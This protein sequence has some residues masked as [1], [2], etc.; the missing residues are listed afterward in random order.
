MAR[1]IA[2]SRARRWIVP[3]FAALIIG[4][5]FASAGAAIE[6]EPGD[7]V[8][9]DVRQPGRVLWIDPI[10]GVQE[11][12]A[13]VEGAVA[14]AV[15]ADRQILVATTSFFS[16][17]TN[18]VVRVDPT[19]GAWSFLTRDGLLRGPTAIAVGSDGEIVVADGFGDT[20]NGSIVR[21]D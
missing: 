8:A 18:G 17:T 7:L 6:L 15:E 1:S 14:A 21:V 9:V 11:V 4:L 5:L 12:I 19:S 13:L 10:T 20:S 16:G 3:R 2:S